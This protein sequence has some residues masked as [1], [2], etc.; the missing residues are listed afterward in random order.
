MK[1]ARPQIPSARHEA[2]I[3]A[4][5]Q[6]RGF[7]SAL[8]AR[9]GIALGRYPF[10]PDAFELNEATR[11]LT[12]WEVVVTNPV[13]KKFWK[14]RA[15]RDQLALR[16][17]SLKLFVAYPSGRFVETD[18]DTGRMTAAEEEVAL[19]AVRAAWSRMR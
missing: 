13:E 15:V 1:R 7:G 11:T 6:T 10:T 4:D 9:L 8:R 19:A 17:W 14:M 5:K 3:P 2:A 18:I 12:L 16:G